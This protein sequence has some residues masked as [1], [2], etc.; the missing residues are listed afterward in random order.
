V[1]DDDVVL[2][3]DDDIELQRVNFISALLLLM[4]KIHYVHN[5]DVFETRRGK[6]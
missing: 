1:S 5:D 4:E 3:D 6:C 2:D